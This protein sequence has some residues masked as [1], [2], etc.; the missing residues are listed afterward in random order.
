VFRQ[1]GKRELLR[2]I[3][4]AVDVGGWR[5]TG[6]H[7]GLDLPFRFSIS[8]GDESEDLA[9]YIWNISHGG[10]TRS[11]N[12]YRIQLKGHGLLHDPDVKTILLGWFDSGRV[13]VAFDAFKHHDFGGYSPSVQVPKQTVETAMRGKIAFHTKVL[14]A[15]SGK[16]VVVAFKHSLLIQYIN[17]IFPEFHDPS[18]EG[19]SN[20]EAEA[21][22][23]N[24]LDRALP[25]GALDRLPQKRRTALVTLNKKLREASFGEDVWRVY[26]GRCAVCGIQAE[27]TEAAHIVPVKDG[28]PDDVRNGVQ[29]CR[30]HH[31]AFDNGLFVIGEDYTLIPNAAEIERLTRLRLR[32]GLDGFID[33]LKVRAKITLPSDSRFNPAREYLIAGRQLRGV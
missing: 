5:S 2:V 14:R 10:A 11:P 8:S 21:L 12:E 16:E 19:I 7:G 30:N 31:K 3:L 25:T 32:D 24:P 22:E 29:L 9:V 4:S 28:G 15:A 20:E 23:L 13:F 26:E 33:E 6:V 18:A 1:L 27:I 17:E